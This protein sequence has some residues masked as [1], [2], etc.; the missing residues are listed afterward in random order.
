MAKVKQ[1]KTEKVKDKEQKCVELTDGTKVFQLDDDIEEL[2]YTAF[3]EKFSCGKTNQKTWIAQ[4][5]DQQ[6]DSLKQSLKKDPFT[7]LSSVRELNKIV[8]NTQNY[9]NSKKAVDTDFSKYLLRDTLFYYQREVFDSPMKKKALCWGRRVG[10]TILAARMALKHCLEKDDKPRECYIIGLTLERTAELYWNEL[11]DQIQKAHITTSKIDNSIYRI[12]FPNNN[13]IQ[14]WGNGSK[15]EAAKLRGKDASMVIIE[16]MQSE[17][18]LFDLL[19]NIVEPMIKARDGEIMCIGTAPLS[20]GTK[21]EEIL[22]DDT[23]FHSEANMSMNPTIPNHERVLEEI[24]EEK[25]W[26]ADNPT[27]IR[28][29]LGKICYD[30]NLLI[31]PK[32]H[33][34][35]DLPNDFNPVEIYIACDL[36]WRDRSAVITMAVDAFGNA[37]VTE[38]FCRSGCDGTTILNEIQRQAELTKKKW[39]VSNDQIHVVCDTNE[40]NLTQDWYNRALSNYICENAIKYELTTSYALVNEALSSGMLKIPEE[41]DCDWDCKKTVYKTDT[42]TGKILYEEDK[43]VWH[44]DAMAALRY[45]WG[46][47]QS[48]KSQGA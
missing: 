1:V 38:E 4:F 7:A 19:E 41:G 30:S 46:N 14:L 2:M 28:E 31:Y 40:Q 27:F 23:Y 17:Q 12:T 42:E 47:Y 29:Y 32:V 43:K 39:D 11:K 36:G 13:F 33:Y 3:A 26:T 10:K 18:R 6:M 21:W 20:A 8:N 44:E 45:A 48:S 9:F 22:G 15:T 16:E 24:L 37:F 25:H 5:V 34:W 35:Y